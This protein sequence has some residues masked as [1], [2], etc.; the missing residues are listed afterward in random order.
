[1]EQI[2]L[3]AHISKKIDEMLEKWVT[4]D[5]ILTNTALY[6]D[7]LFYFKKELIKSI[8]NEITNISKNSFSI[9]DLKIISNVFEDCD[10]FFTTF[11]PL[12]KD[13]SLLWDFQQFYFVSE[14][15]IPSQNEF[16]IPKMSK[17]HFER[18]SKLFI[19]KTY[20]SII[21][22]DNI[23]FNAIASLI[24]KIGLFKK[25][26][27]SFYNFISRYYQ[28]Q[29][30]LYQKKKLIQ[31]SEYCITLD[32]IPKSFYPEILRSKYQILDWER[33]FQIDT[34]NIFTTMNPEG[35]LNHPSLMMDTKY[36]N[37]EFKD[38]L[39]ST[40]EDIDSALNG[41]IIHGENFDGLELLKSKFCQ[42]IDMIYIDPPYN[43]GKDE[44]RYKDNYQHLSWLSMMFASLLKLKFLSASKS[45]LFIS[46][47][48]IEKPYLEILADRLFKRDPSFGPIIVQ[49]N[50]GGR[51]YLPIAKSHEYILC[52]S[53][54]SEFPE[55]NLL[56]KDPTEYKY[57]DLYGKWLNRELRN[58]NP[59]FN[60]QN[61]PNLFYPFFIN[62]KNCDKD[63]F[64]VVSL[65]RTK[66]HSIEIYPRDS[67]GRDDCWRWGKEKAAL[68]LDPLF[69][70]KSHLVA[71]QRPDGGWNIYEKYRK[72]TQKAKSLWL[73][74]EFRTE[75]GT[76]QIRKLFGKSVIDFPKPFELIQKCV[77][78]GS[79]SNSFILDFFAGSGSTAHAVIEQNI[80]D[81]GRR[82]YLLIEK[83]DYFSTVLLPRI[84]KIVY[85]REWKNGLPLNPE[86]RSHF[87]KYLK[88]ET[89]CN[90]LENF[91]L[92]NS[93]SNNDKNHLKYNLSGNNDHIQ[94]SFNFNIFNEPFNVFHLSKGKKIPLDLI[95]T[96]NYL[97][98]FHLSKILVIKNQTVN[99]KI[100]KGFIENQTALIIWRDIENLDLQLDAHFIKEEILKDPIDHLYV[101]T[102]CL[103]DSANIIDHEFMLR[104]FKSQ[105]DS[106]SE[107]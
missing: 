77:A 101:N 15:N 22:Y 28:L 18:E 100:L 55:I 57:Q 78:L 98:G 56:P 107:D 39:L 35:L 3:R 93:K 23:D 67:K 19:L 2:P 17:K 27:M 30:A 70:E 43:R 50:A 33:N 38:R 46:I 106:P 40:F 69:P 13:E 36:F 25:C 47:D 83:A 29:L 72:I 66:T 80:K 87:F 73:D 96:F 61:R 74:S 81:D 89:Y 82:K 1:M 6:N 12:N 31:K 104:M 58:R 24:T 42:K 99:Y 21:E 75:N 37:L 62:P 20:P 102:K 45:S 91:Q 5:R 63:K 95:E 7:Y 103:I 79:K 26:L 60:R 92:I 32:L 44:F 14:C 11:L 41:I 8:N 53:T 105:I 16:F 84:K 71:R 51:D 94:I 76:I 10:N 64:C 90:T 4:K 97:I 54:G 85:S 48:D 68:N 52:F 86:K 34:H 88:I 9:I 49:V 65:E 59:R